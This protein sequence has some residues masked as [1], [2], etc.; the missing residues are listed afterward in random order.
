LA[1]IAIVTLIIIAVAGAAGLAGAAHPA[2]TKQPAAAAP[3]EAG[4][5]IGCDESRT[6]RVFSGGG[7]GASV[8]RV[9]AGAPKVTRKIAATFT[10]L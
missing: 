6:A 5:S 3:S 2:E 8:Q 4:Y 1:T 9:R 7:E 10:V